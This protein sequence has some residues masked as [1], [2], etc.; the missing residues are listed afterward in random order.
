MKLCIVTCYNQPDYV[1]AKT[2][3]AAAALLDDVDTIVIKNSRTGLLRYIEVMIR[4]LSARIKHKPDVY[5]LTFRGYE[6]LLPMRLLTLKKKLVYDEFINPIEWVVHERRQ[7]EPGRKSRRLQGVLVR[8]ASKIIVAVVSSGLF[9]WFYRKL[10]ESTDLILTDTD[11]HADL[12]AWLTG[13]SRDKY[14]MIPVGTDEATFDV[15]EPD[16][17]EA[18]AFTVLYYG[19][20]L[21]LH[22]VD[23]VI[24]AAVKMNKKP[25]RFV[26]IG[27]SSKIAHQAAFA[28]GNGANIDY[29]AWVEFETLPSVIRSADLCLAGP[30]GNTYQSNYVI[31]GKAFQYMAMG[32]PMVVGKNKESHVFRDKRDALIVEQGD[33]DALVNTIEWAMRNRTRLRAIGLKGQ[34]LY[35]ANYTTEKLAKHLRIGLDRLSTLEP[36]ARSE[37]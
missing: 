11:S 14:L 13:V 21:P 20:M 26:L 4:V 24:K 10:L 22:G 2:L 5:I 6:M 37:R 35:T 17:S 7:V 3:R 27:G 25:V 19:S 29:K 23:K 15:V 8:I 12:S 30:F 28:V 31:T 36:A 33:A 32:K 34:Q 9:K 1:R 18:D 16:D